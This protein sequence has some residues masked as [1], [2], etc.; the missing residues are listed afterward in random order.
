VVEG[1]GSKAAGRGV[2][3]GGRKPDLV[4]DEGKGLKP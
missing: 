2:L 1:G 4:L 3:G